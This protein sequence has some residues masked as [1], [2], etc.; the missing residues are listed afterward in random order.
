MLPCR[1]FLIFLDTT[2]YAAKIAG[3]IK[4]GSEPHAIIDQNSGDLLVTNEEI[5]TATLA[6]CV[7]NL[8]SKEPDQE[9]KD[10]VDIKARVV[11]EML[12]V[13]D[14]ESLE[15]YEDDFETVCKKF[16]SKQTKSYDFLLKAGPKYQNVIFKLCKRMITEEIFPTLFRKTLLN[17][18]WKQKG[19]A[20]VLKNN[21]FIHLKEHYL[22]RTVEALV[23]NKM[24]GL[25]GWRAARALHR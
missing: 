14:E 6:Y 22:P 23:V 4:S 13:N 9:A 12:K 20:E 10:I 7:E 21:R 5:K 11:E 18:I 3:G 8:K 24:K 16:N 15:I 19:L 2:W 25:S 17:M 1:C